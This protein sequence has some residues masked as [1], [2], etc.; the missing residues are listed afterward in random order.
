MA[1]RLGKGVKYPITSDSHSTAILQELIGCINVTRKD[2]LTRRDAANTQPLW[3]I[4][5]V[6]EKKRDDRKSAQD[7]LK[8][9][10]RKFDVRH[11]QDFKFFRITTIEHHQ[12]VVD[13]FVKIALVGLAGGILEAKGSG[14]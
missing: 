11:Y 14:Y 4:E 3:K 8:C 7:L 1:A 6:Q 12:C 2:W 5:A 9:W 13:W 10:L